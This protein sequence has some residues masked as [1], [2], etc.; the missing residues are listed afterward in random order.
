MVPMI[1]VSGKSRSSC[2]LIRILFWYFFLYTKR[3]TKHLSQDI[4][5]LP[6]TWKKDYF[7]ITN[8]SLNKYL[9]LI[10][11]VAT[12]GTTSLSYTNLV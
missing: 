4:C 3:I 9:K 10:L 1:Y 12:F 11:H 7:K 8:N 2:G 6:D 5:H